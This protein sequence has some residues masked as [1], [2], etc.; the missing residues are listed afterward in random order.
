MHSTG[1]AGTI[2]A[3]SIEAALQHWKKK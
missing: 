1:I 2:D 3:D